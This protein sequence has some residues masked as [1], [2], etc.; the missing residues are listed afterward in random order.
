MGWITSDDPD[1][2]V[3]RQIGRGASGEVYEVFP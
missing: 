3:C 1:S 2:H